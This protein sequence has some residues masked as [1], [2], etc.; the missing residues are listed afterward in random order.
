[1]RS[2]YR[3][4]YGCGCVSGRADR[5]RQLMGYCPLH[6][7]SRTALWTED[8]DNET[9]YANVPQPKP[10]KHTMTKKPTR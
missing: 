8:D 2:W 3:E 7:Q 9:P 10:R 4:L 1:M 6:G 5:K